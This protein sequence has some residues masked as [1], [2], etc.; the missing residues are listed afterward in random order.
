MARGTILPV[1]R[2]LI[3]PIMVAGVEKRFALLNA[4]IAFPL[5]AATHLHVP[6]CLVG[7]LLYGFLHFVF[8]LISKNDPHLG[9]VLKRSTRYCV[10]PYFPAH[11]HPLQTDIWKIRSVSRPL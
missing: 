7:V 8:V 4:M 10:R 2:A 11:S 6:A 9:K 5:I 1:N 3:R